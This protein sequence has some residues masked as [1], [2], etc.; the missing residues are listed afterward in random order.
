MV[1]FKVLLG[2]AAVLFLA[3]GMALADTSYAYDSGTANGGITW[4]PGYLYSVN[5]FPTGSNNIINQVSVAWGNLAPGTAAAV[6]LYSMPA[7]ALPS[8]NGGVPSSDIQVLQ[9]VSTTVTSLQTNGAGLYFDGVNNAEHFYS[10]PTGPVNIFAGATGE[11]PATITNPVWSTYSIPSTAITTPYFA[12]G[13]IVYNTDQNTIAPTLLDLSTVVTN[14]NMNISWTGIDG[15]SSINGPAPTSMNNS[16]LG[17]GN[18]GDNYVAYFGPWGTT[19]GVKGAL[20]NNLN[21]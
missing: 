9:T 6:V 2:I 19:F 13:T 8:L 15:A 1:R 5:I 14:P 17:L 11:T 3:S 7:D 12:V 4:W 16:N 18:G 21:N 20:I 10:S